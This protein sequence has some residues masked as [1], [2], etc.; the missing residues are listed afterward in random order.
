MNLR[1][2]NR[3]NVFE[4]FTAG[5]PTNKRLSQSRHSGTRHA[6]GSHAR[7]D[8]PVPHNKI[9]AVL[10]EHAVELCFLPA[11]FNTSTSVLLY[12]AHFYTDKSG[13]TLSATDAWLR[14]ETMSTTDEIVVFS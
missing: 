12:Y 5:L 4:Y 3:P 9:D 8:G 11:M 2:G 1:L 14:T 6:N 7:G 10:A 13:G